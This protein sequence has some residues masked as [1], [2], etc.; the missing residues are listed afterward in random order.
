MEN[1]KLITFIIPAYNAQS[2]L[3]QCLD[4]L[5]NQTLNSHKVIIVDDGSTD[6][7]AEIAQSYVQQSPGMFY[8]IKQENA[9]QGS[10]RNN[11]LRYVDTPFTSFLDSDDWQNNRFVEAVAKELSRQDEMPDIIFTLPWIY[12]SATK[13]ILE[14]YD[15]PLFDKLFYPNEENINAPSCVLNVNI[16][17]R[18]FEF[19]VNVCRRVFRTQFLRD[20][21][22][23]FPTKVKWE[24][25]KP[26][27]D[28][29]HHAKRCIAIRNVGFFYR[30]NSAEQTTA[31]KGITRLDIIPVFQDAIQSAIQEGWDKEQIA[32]IL[33]IL[34]IFVTWSIGITN[35]EYI[36]PLL[37]GLHVLMKSIPKQY[38]DV[39][40]NIC[41]PYKRRDM[42][43]IWLLKSPVYLLLKDYRTRQKGEEFFNSIR[44]IRNRLRRK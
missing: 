38:V 28:A 1:E 29:L 12:D 18:L 17:R 25:V 4:S 13:R 7:T 11:G 41:S 22:F 35:T 26:H 32:Y 14:W 40:L 27:F 20:I 34:M 33:R 2:W 44:R 24:D 36:Q 37:K 39:Y 31:G 9:G 21:G 5:M 10:A 43:L 15:K 3:N 23:S 8:Y 19:E 42:L 6:N 16:D 30:I